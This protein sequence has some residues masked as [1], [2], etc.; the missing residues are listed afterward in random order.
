MSAAWPQFLMDASIVGLIRGYAGIGAP[1]SMSCSY[2][3]LGRQIFDPW[4]FLTRKDEV[5][6]RLEGLEF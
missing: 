5:F 4:D 1:I 6:K 3:L 2:R